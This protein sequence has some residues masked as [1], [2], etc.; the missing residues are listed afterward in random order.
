MKWIM[1]LVAVCV[2][3]LLVV[4]PASAETMPCDQT[5]IQSLADCVQHAAQMGA[6]DNQ[7]VANSLLAQV[8][9]AQS[10]ANHGDT[11]A[12]VKI[13]QAFINEVR[14]QAGKH[15]DAAHAGHMV[16][17]AQNVRAALRG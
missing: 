6:I 11:A 10:A 4:L 3:S 5:T 9:A 1:V 2:V 12:A 8:S 7:G 14:A 16:M 17:H 15:I 13:L